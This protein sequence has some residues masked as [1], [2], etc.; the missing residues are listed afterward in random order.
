MKP[1]NRTVFK[2]DEM[3]LFSVAKLLTTGFS[4]IR[5]GERIILIP[6][7]GDGGQVGELAKEPV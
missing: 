4:E 1:I 2:F 7:P 3:S 6:S 5:C